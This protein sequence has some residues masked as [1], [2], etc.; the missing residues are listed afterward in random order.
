MKNLLISKSIPLLLLLS[1]TAKANFLSNPGFENS[2]TDWQVDTGA[3]MTRAADPV[4]YEGD[5]YIFGADDFTI[6]QSVDL[7]SAGLTT[8]AIDAGNLDLNFGGWQSGWN[9]MDTG[10]ISI[11]LLDASMNQIGEAQLSSF[12]SSKVWEEQSGTT[13]LLSGTRFVSYEFVGIRGFGNNNDAYLDA[14][15][16]TISN[17]PVPASLYLFGSALLGLAGLKRKK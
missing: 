6:S 15:Y 10:Q 17:V 16:L 1:V 13:D 3:A 4:A 11:Y 5:Y 12:T 14:A 7:L 9:G 2:L 8:A